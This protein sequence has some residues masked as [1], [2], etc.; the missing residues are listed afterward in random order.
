MTPKKKTTAQHAD[1]IKK[2]DNTRFRSTQ[3]F[4]RYKYFFEKAPIIQERFMDLVDLNDY[5]IPGC[6]QDRGWEKL[7]GYLPK[8]CEPLIREFYVNAIL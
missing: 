5:F 2:M 7:L 8:V 6:F 3:H 4:E 1:K